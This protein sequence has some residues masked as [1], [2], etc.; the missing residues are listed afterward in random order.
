M[1]DKKKAGAFDI[2]VVIAL[3]IGIYGVVLTILGIVEKQPEVDKAAGININL[4]GGIGMLVFTA[5]FVAWARLRPIAV[6]IEEES[7]DQ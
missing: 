4:W 2:R 6:P 7:T 1:A 3:L 5:L